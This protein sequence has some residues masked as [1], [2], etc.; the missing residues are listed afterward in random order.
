VLGRAW[1][2]VEERAGLD[3]KRSLGGRETLLPVVL[4]LVQMQQREGVQ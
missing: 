4:F 2:G 3:C 1:A